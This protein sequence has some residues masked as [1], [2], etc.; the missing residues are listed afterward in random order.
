MLL[1][2]GTFL[3]ASLITLLMGLPR[4]GFAQSAANVARALALQ[5]LLDSIE[6]VAEESIKTGPRSSS[7]PLS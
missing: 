1:K 3:I 7:L 6:G 2:K 5:Q 4:P